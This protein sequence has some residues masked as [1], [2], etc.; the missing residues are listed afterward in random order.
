VDIGINPL[1]INEPGLM[2]YR[3]VESTFLKRAANEGCRP[4]DGLLQAT[5]RERCFKKDRRGKTSKKI[6]FLL[7]PAV[8][9]PGAAKGDLAEP[10]SP[11]VTIG[12]NREAK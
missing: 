9:P 3:F 8:L 7:K 12:K 10:G 11:E 1:R 6:I 4:E 2:E 5:F